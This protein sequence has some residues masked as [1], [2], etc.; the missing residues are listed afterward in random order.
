VDWI[1]EPAQDAALALQASRTS[2]GE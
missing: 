1:A 2:P